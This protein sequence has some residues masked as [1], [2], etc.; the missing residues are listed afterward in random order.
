MPKKRMVGRA[1]ALATAAALGMSGLWVAGTAHAAPEEET[2]KLAPTS[3]D[4]Y[5]ALVKEITQD[6]D[7]SVVGVGEDN[8]LVIMTTDLSTGFASKAPTV[9]VE[10]IVAEYDNVVIETLESPLTSHAV[11]DLVGGAGYFAAATT[12]PSSGGTCSVGFNGFDGSGNPVVLSAG[13]CTS[14]GDFQ[15]TWTTEPTQDTA[16]NPGGGPVNLQAEL[17]LYE[18]FRFG[19]GATPT[20]PGESG[21]FGSTD[22]SVIEVTNGDLDPLAE[23]TEWPEPPTNDLASQTYEITGVASPEV[24]DE[25]CHSGRTTGYYCSPVTVGHG[26]AQVSGRWVYGFGGMLNS[27]PGDSGGSIT[28]GN[29]AAGLLSGGNDAGF[30]WAADLTNAL[31]V[32]GEYTVK[33]AVDAPVLTNPADG[34]EVERGGTISGTAPVGSEVTIKIGSEPSF[35]VPV[36]GAGNW[37]FVAPGETGSITFTA[38]AAIGYS[39]ST[40]ATFTVDV[41]AAPLAAPAVTSP[42][43]GSTVETSVSEIT[44]TGTPGAQVELSGDVEGEATVAGDGT[45]VVE[46]DDALS[47]GSYNAEAVQTFEGQTS[48]ATAFSFTV[49]PVA[50]VITD[51]AD[52]ANFGQNA[53]PSEVSGTGVEGA[54]VTVYV[55]GVAQTQIGLVDGGEWSVTLDAQVGAGTHTISALQE[56]NDVNS[57]TA[58]VTVTVAGAPAPTPTP[59]PTAP[60]PG[61]GGD[62]G[63]LA[64]TGAI[65]WPVAAGGALLL[66]AGIILMLRRRVQNDA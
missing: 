41:V 7:V 44:G 28:F 66:A 42:A 17:G 6:P 18:Y 37:S 61:D 52:G 27:A 51:P 30:T 3:G 2:K 58:S 20:D 21:D 31:D 54:S 14:N 57:A 13:H 15:Y 64:S 43:N 59:T 47:Y 48:P 29:S 16:Y 60:A 9:S 56:V 5:L 65:V 25:I 23:V 33:V 49:A 19:G 35:D 63:G 53:G 40:T 45:W 11:N 34:G 1:A 26:W 46:L 32:A 38:Q 39:K 22:I 12:S 4:G 10:D 24:G 8:N 62:G 36:D 55:D 50:P